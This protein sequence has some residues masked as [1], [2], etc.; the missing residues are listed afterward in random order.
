VPLGSLSPTPIPSVAVD[1]TLTTATVSWPATAPAN[2]INRTTTTACPGLAT[3]CP[4]PVCSNNPALPCSAPF[5][6][7]VQCGDFTAICV[8]GDPPLADTAA[9]GPEPIYGVQLFVHKVP[10]TGPGGTL[11]RTLSDMEGVPGTD[12]IAV[13]QN[14]GAQMGCTGSGGDTRC[15]GM[16][17]IPCSSVT[18]GSCAV[19]GK[20]FNPV[21]Q[22]FTM[23]DTD[24][25]TFLGTDGPLGPGEAAVL[26]TKVMFRGSVPNSTASGSAFTNDNVVSLFSANSTAFSFDALISTIALDVRSEQ[27]NRVVGTIMAVGG[28]YVSFFVEFAGDG[29]RFEPLT[30]IEATGA[31]EYTFTHKVTGYRAAQSVYRVTGELADGNTIQILKTVDLT[32]A[33]GRGGNSHKLT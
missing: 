21:A 17:S 11:Y 32:R 30:T 18:G 3:F 14:P 27:A 28:P 13:H 23:T 26:N 15:P 4:D 5:D 25:N 29:I 19:D 9:N 10:T 20:T 22:S 12:P 16:W 33:R 1:P 2:T 8:C 24:V 31:E 6:P 7:Y